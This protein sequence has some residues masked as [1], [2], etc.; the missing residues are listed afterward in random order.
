MGFMDDLYSTDPEDN[1]G[2]HEIFKQWQSLDPATKTS[3]IDQAEMRLQSAARSLIRVW[4]DAVVSQ[5]NQPSF[6]VGINTI[7]SIE[8]GRLGHYENTDQFLMVAISALVIL[9]RE[10]MGVAPP[11]LEPLLED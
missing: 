10:R 4:S 11:D 9:L 2:M 7:E 1:S 8:A 5:P 3:I 6:G